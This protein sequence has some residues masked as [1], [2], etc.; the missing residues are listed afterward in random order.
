MRMAFKHFDRDGDGA[1]SP[2]ELRAALVEDGDEAPSAEDARRMIA[3]V[4]E[5]GDG[6]VDWKE[7][8]GFGLFREG[9]AAGGEWG[10]GGDEGGTTRPA[11]P[12]VSHPSP[13]HP[14][15]PVQAYD[16][17]RPPRRRRRLALHHR[18]DG[19]G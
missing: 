8:G 10:M 12:L 17:H 19:A 13:P 9:E 5:D 18:R 6:A 1:I 4:D 11:R 2:A 3:A 16:A 14:P 15:H 7:V